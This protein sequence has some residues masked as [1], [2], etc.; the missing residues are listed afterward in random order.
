MLKNYNYGNCYNFIP[1]NDLSAIV[2]AVF[3]FRPKYELKFIPFV[4]SQA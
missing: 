2:N 3:I 1:C 4:V